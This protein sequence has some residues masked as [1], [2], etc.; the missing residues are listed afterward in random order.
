MCIRDSYYIVIHLAKLGANGNNETTQEDEIPTYGSC[1]EALAAGY[2]GE[3]IMYEFNNEKIPLTCEH[4]IDNGGWSLILDEHEDLTEDNILPINTLGLQ[5]EQILFKV[6]EGYE[7]NSRNNDPVQY[8]FDGFL[9]QA[10]ALKFGETWYVS[11]EFDINFSYDRDHLK[12]KA[13]Y[14][15]ADQI[16]VLEPS[17]TCYFED[18]NQPNYC[19]KSFIFNAP[20]PEGELNAISDVESLGKYA[21]QNNKWNAYFKLYVR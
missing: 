2:T 18:S 20:L 15:Q 7:Y 3:T 14:K 19:A 16:T 4:T 5:Y 10:N 13:F 12:E 8:K 9:F 21:Y 17:E 1:K 11:E 6:D